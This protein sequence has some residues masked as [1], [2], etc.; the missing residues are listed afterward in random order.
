MTR[1]S[2]G[3]RRLAVAAGAT[4]ALLACS[5]STA[6]GP[7]GP[8]DLLLSGVWEST[9]ANPAGSYVKIATYAAG[10]QI[11]GVGVAY[12]LATPDS[13]RIGGQYLDNGSFGLS[14]DYSSGRS[15]AFVGA[16][17]GTAALVGTW[18]DGTS[19]ASYDETFAR[20]S[21][22]PCSDS[23]PLL[24]TYDPAAPGFIVRFQDSVNAA[25]EAARLAALYNFTT[26]FVYD[27][28]IKGFAA[29]LPMSTVTVLR[30]EPKV[31]S[32]SYDATVTIGGTP[33]LR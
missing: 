24:G 29:D 19:G 15:A 8:Q 7:K 27:V 26:T 23:T 2:R 10:G 6:P 14:I 3:T 17:H 20:L 12:R 32:I 4:A 18:T 1:I 22:P 16:V 11:T 9:S 21:V 30:C 28:A 33:P 13:L 31:T 5:E 25:A